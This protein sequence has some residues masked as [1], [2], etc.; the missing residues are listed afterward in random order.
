MVL[1]EVH[2][3][4][5]QKCKLLHHRKLTAFHFSS[6]VNAYILCG[7][8]DGQLCH[9]EEYFASVLKGTKRNKTFSE[10]GIVAVLM[11]KDYTAP[12]VFDIQKLSVSL[13]KGPFP[14]LVPC[15]FYLRT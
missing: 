1:S 9:I 11:C 8:G 12:K 10:T 14:V 4:N 6:F 3:N 5:K 13:S 2:L 7:F 15:S